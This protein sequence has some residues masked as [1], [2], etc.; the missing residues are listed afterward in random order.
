MIFTHLK[1]KE[2]ITT[3]RIKNTNNLIWIT[4]VTKEY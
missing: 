4:Y 1:S 2:I 3:Q